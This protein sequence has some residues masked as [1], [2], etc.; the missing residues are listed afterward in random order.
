MKRYIAVAGNI[1]A[2]KTSLVEFL[3]RRYKLKPF[4]EP[5]DE[6]PYLKDF[7]KDMKAWAFHS[8][9]YFLTHKFRLHRELERFPKTVIQDRTIYEDA[10]IFAKNLHRSRYINKRDYATYR[11][12]YETIRKDLTPPDIMIFLRCSVRTM[13][14]RIK[15]RGRGMEQQIPTRYLRRLDSLY[16]EWINNYKLSPLIEIDSD[17]MDYVTDLVHRLDLLKAIEKIL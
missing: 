4:Y 1:G 12:M 15:Q 8:Q 5:N 13:R 6:N 11:E 14:R 17:R 10:E 9:I 7:Y 16:A 3:V 2:G